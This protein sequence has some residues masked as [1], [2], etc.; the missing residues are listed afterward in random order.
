MQLLGVKENISA[1]RS[2]RQLRQEE[3]SKQ[4][5]TYDTMYCVA[6]SIAAHHTV[7]SIMYRQSRANSQVSRFL[8]FA[9]IM[10]SLS[11]QMFCSD[12]LHQSVSFLVNVLVQSQVPG[13]RRVTV[14]LLDLL[15]SSF[16]EPLLILLCCGVDA[17]ES[18]LV[19]PVM[20]QSSVQQP[21]PLTPLCL[22]EPFKAV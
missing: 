22:P 5:N 10:M 11:A 3:V 2:Q 4:K 19:Y 1:P 18:V 15:V 14:I 21:A 16:Y 7:I 6:N 8:F 17:L 12:Q 13:V 9:V 20:K